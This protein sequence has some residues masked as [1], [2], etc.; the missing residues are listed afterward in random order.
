MARLAVLCPVALQLAKVARGG[1]A[2]LALSSKGLS[3]LMGLGVRANTTGVTAV[4]P[5]DSG[6]VLL[7]GSGLRVSEVAAL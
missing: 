7:T 4:P 5:A 6:Q 3:L 1:A 2:G